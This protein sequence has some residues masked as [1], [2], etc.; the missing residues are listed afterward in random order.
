VTSKF[1]NVLLNIYNSRV[2]YA[3]RLQST[4]R[5][6]P[7]KYTFARFTPAAQSQ[8]ANGRV[9]LIAR[10]RARF[11]DRSIMTTARSLLGDADDTASRTGTSVASLERLLVASLAEVIGAGVGDDGSAND[12]LGA[13]ELDEAVLDGALGV[14]LGVGLDV[15]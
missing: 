10:A 14:A 5:L 1:D 8:T 12:A 3:N 13:D 7:A 4:R 15:A 2:E 11:W 9:A 6:P